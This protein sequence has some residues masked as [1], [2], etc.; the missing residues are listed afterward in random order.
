MA[1][2]ALPSRVLFCAQLGSA[3]T[4]PALRTRPRAR[5]RNSRAM[6]VAA[7]GSAENGTVPSNGAAAAVAITGVAVYSA[8]PYVHDFL[9]GASPARGSS[10]AG[11][12]TALA[13]PC[14]GLL[15]R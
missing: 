1:C 9:E 5:P 15:P 4:A 14:A 3:R 13:F 10:S 2:R 11:S 7:Q 12:R 6:P 8:A